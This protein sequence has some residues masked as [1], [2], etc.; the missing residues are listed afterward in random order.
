MHHSLTCGLVCSLLL[1][2]VRNALPFLAVNCAVSLMMSRSMKVRPSGT[3]TWWGRRVWG[4]GMH[5]G[6]QESLG[7]SSCT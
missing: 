2:P 5:L 4:W 3:C 1:S 6:G 7:F